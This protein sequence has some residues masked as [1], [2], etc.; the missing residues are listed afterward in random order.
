MEY[1]A[2]DFDIFAVGHFHHKAVEEFVRGDQLRLA[3][4]MGTY[5]KEGIFEMSRGWG[6]A[7]I[8]APG[9][10]LWPDKKKWMAF[11]TVEDGVEYLQTLIDLERSSQQNANS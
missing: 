9:V 4:R 5:R 11:R 2:P 7:E 8:G 1:Y 10:M 3:V 6:H